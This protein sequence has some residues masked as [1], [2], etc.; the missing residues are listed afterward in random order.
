MYTHIL[1]IHLIRLCQQ[2]YRLWNTVP[3]SPLLPPLPLQQQKQQTVVLQQTAPQRRM[4]VVFL[5]DVAGVY[6]KS[7]YLPGAELIRHITVRTDGTVRYIYC[8]ILICAWS[9]KYIA[10]ND[11]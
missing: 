5:T 2:Q 9:A 8:Y 11:N 6:D 3:T 4:R 7:P 1:P 10:I